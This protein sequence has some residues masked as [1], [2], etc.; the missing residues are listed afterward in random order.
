MAMFRT[1]APLAYKTL[2]EVASMLRSREITAVELTQAVLKQIATHEP[3]LHAYSTQAAAES[4]LA[5]ARAADQ[6]IAKLGTTR[7]PLHGV[8]IAVKDLYAVA[9]LPNMGG[10]FALRDNL[11]TEDCTVV[12]RLRKHGAILLGKL[13]TTEGAMGGYNPLLPHPL[14]VNPWD[15]SSWAG[16]SSSGSGVATSAGL[17][18]A[19]LGSD[20]GGSIRFPAASCGTCG[21][22]P[23]RGRCSRHGVLDLAQT[24][25]HVGPLTRCSADSAIVLQAIGGHDPEDPTSLH[26]PPPAV[27]ASSSDGGWQLLMGD[28]SARLGRPVRIGICQPYNSTDVDPE[29]AAAVSAAAS[30]LASATGVKQPASVLFYR[31]LLGI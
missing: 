18:Y 3:S 9:G 20:T 7:G 28:V 21:V 16:A 11:P 17:A 14:P 27:W 6:Q 8:P 15:A 25:D 26:A 31:M 23:T 2:L 12:Q 29:L 19:T 30:T 4:A 13:N 24:L 5:E 10:S 1:D 22:K